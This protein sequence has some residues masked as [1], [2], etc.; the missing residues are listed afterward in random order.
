[1]TAR[2]DKRRLGEQAVSTTALL[3]LLT[4]DFLETL[5]LAVIA[6]GRHD[7]DAHE[8]QWARR[9]SLVSPTAAIFSSDIAAARSC[10]LDPGR[11][12]HVVPVRAATFSH[13]WSQRFGDACSQVGVALELAC[14][15]VTVRGVRR[16]D[17]R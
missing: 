6:C 8:S 3:P 1:M 15:A 10:N 7:V 2:I 11:R 9:C 12:S 4:D 14:A 16:R 17:R 13:L 5:R